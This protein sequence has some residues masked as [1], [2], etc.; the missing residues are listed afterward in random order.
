VRE[1]NLF[2]LV[3][4]VQSLPFLS[5][6]ALAVLDGTKFNDFATWRALD[7]RLAD[8][9]RRRPAIAEVPAQVVQREP[10]ELAQ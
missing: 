3:L 8:M 2:A 4:V 7:L 9:V 1:I 6:T 10:S 5:A